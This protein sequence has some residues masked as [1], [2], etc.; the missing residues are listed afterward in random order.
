MK[1]KEEEHKERIDK[2]DKEM[3][4]AREIWERDR[5]EYERRQRELAERLRRRKKKKGWGISI[6]PVHIEL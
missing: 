5:Q 3:Q 4:K 2:M 6:G 1:T